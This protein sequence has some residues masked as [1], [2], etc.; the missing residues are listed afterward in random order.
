MIK[1]S[2]FKTTQERE[3]YYEYETLDEST[4]SSGDLIVFLNGLSDSIESWSHIKTYFKTSHSFLFIDMIGQGKSLEK[5]EALTDIFFDY[6]ISAE[7]QADGI[8]ELIDFLEIKKNFHLV[9]FSYGGGIA[10]RFAS[11]FPYKIKKLILFLPYIIRLDLAF[12]LQ[13]LWAGQINFFKNVTPLR[14][15]MM[16]F[17]QAYQK[18]M[19]EYMNYRFSNKIPDGHKRQI[20]IQLTE[21]IMPFNAFHFFQSLPS[22]AVHLITVDHDTLVPK[23]LYQET[24]D[25]LPEEK[26]C[27]WLRIEDGEHLIFDQSPLFCVNWIESL[28]GHHN[29]SKPKRFTANSYKMEVFEVDETNSFNKK[30]YKV[31]I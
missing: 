6:R 12:P 16:I 10:I 5:E 8:K 21:G 7:Q 31:S 14:P 22:H 26:K 15:S 27:T 18:M 23:S 1:K 20:S 11:L 29:P 17:D 4:K 3:L 25:R 13:R 2:F 19:R 9:G 28:I 30:A 24:W